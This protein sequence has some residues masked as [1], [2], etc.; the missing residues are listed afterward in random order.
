MNASPIDE[1]RFSYEIYTEKLLPPMDHLTHIAKVSRMI[2]RK[3][4]MDINVNTF[5]EMWGTGDA[6]ARQK[7]I[8]KVEKWISLQSQ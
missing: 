2:D 8:K 6:D 7:M 3:Q 4:K 1:P 5:G